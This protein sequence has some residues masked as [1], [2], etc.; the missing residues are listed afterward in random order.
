M[1]F[2]DR[3]PWHGYD[4]PGLRPSGFFTRRAPLRARPRLKPSLF[5]VRQS[6]FASEGSP[7]FNFDGTLKSLFEL[8]RSHAASS[9]QTLSASAR[10]SYSSYMNTIAREYGHHRVAWLIEADMLNW[11]DRWSAPRKFEERLAGAQVAK[12][13][14]RN[15]L[16]FGAAIGI[17]GCAELV[18]HVPLPRWHR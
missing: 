4:A 17:G 11:C 14:L 15:A 3:A 12:Q 2:L 18:Q 16:K 5:L 7:R 8:Y 6:S 13:S 1:I 9:F 10:A